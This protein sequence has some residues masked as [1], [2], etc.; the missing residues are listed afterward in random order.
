[1]E[2]GQPQVE[3]GE[4]GLSWLAARAH[5]VAVRQV[6]LRVRPVAL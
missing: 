2:L 5:V 1:M 4:S 3:H 6:D